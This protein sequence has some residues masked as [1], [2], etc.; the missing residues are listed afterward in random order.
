[1]KPSILILL[2]VC[3]ICIAGYGQGLIALQERALQDNPTLMAYQ[4]AF[5]AAW[6]KVPQA[7]SLADP[8]ISIGAFVSPVETRVGPQQMRLS[9]SQVFPWFGVLKARGEAA[10]LHAEAV[11]EEWQDAQLRVMRDVGVVYCQLAAQ[12]SLT[13]IEKAHIEVL[14]RLKQIAETRIEQG[15]G[16]V[17]DVLQIDLALQDAEVRAVNLQSRKEPLQSSL[18]AL[19]HAPESLKFSVRKLTAMSGQDLWKGVEAT[20][21]P[22]WTALEKRKRSYEVQAQLARRE[23]MPRIG[24]GIDY[25]GVGMRSDVTG[26]PANGRDA[27]M[28]RL[29]LSIPVYRAKYEAAEREAFLLQEQQSWQ[30][31]ALNDEFQVQYEQA[32]NTLEEQRRWITHYDQQTQRVSHIISQ[33]LVTF[34]N[35]QGRI[36]DILALHEQQLTYQKQQTVALSTYHQVQ[37]QLAYL[38]S[39]Y[40]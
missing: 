24:L 39:N 18:R 9:L 1:M 7:K 21:H 10:T 32:I 15:E 28:P 30:Q 5:E 17:V 34:S 12:D 22:K 33:L 26:L 3:S 19:L 29:Q 36:E 23:G 16:S 11:F 37:I 40:E 31:R 6:A 20:L 4:K 27:W 14:V 38:T 13:R 35:G 8:D 25:I 2:L